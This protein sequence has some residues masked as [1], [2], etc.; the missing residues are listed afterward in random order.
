M[1]QFTHGELTGLTITCQSCLYNEEIVYSNFNNIFYFSYDEENGGIWLRFINPH[2][3]I[4]CG[5]QIRDICIS[6]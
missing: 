1:T 4:N 3:C 6:D 2:N 5:K